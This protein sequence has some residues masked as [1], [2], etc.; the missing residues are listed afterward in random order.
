MQAS[1]FDLSLKGLPDAELDI[2]PIK[3]VSLRPD[4]RQKLLVKVRRNPSVGQSKSTVFQFVLTP[5]KGEVKEVI[6]IDSQFI[7]P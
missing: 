2:S 3:D 5:T 1:S 4:E 6:Y 7:A